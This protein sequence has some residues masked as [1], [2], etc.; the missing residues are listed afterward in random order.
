MAS[1][2]SAASPSIYQTID[3]LITFGLSLT[4]KQDG[5]EEKYDIACFSRSTIS[6]LE[7]SHLALQ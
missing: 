6:N 4:P 1:H 3:D 7:Q 2:V 5:E